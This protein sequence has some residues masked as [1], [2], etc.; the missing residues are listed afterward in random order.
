[1]ADE[2]SSPDAKKREEEEIRARDAKRKKEE[3]DRKRKIEEEKKADAK[4]E[5]QEK[6]KRLEEERRRLK[7]EEEAKRMG[8]DKIVDLPPPPPSLVDDSDPLSIKS[9]HL[10]DEASKPTLRI[11]SLKPGKKTGMPRT[12]L[13]ILKELGVSYFRINLNDFTVL[14]CYV[15]ERLYKHLD[16][17]KV[18][19]TCKDESFIEKWFSEHFNEDE[20]LRLVTDGSCYHD[21]RSKGDTWVR[22]HLKA[23]DCI[24]LPAGMYHRATLDE[25]DFCSILRLFRDAQRWTP[26]FRSEKKA[27]NHPARLLYTKQLKK[28]NVS[29][30]MGVK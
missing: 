9:W 3:E 25:D 29:V 16:E 10:D 6:L 15:K 26:V 20:Q 22:V 14:N 7:A 12:T 28:G 13:A 23:G 18:S 5:Q 27:E 30:E 24:V 4:R 1:M 19:Q 8:S 11:A 21:I 2:P 17:I